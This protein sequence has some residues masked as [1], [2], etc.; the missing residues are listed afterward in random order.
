MVDKRMIDSLLS[1]LLGLDPDEQYTELQV[2][3]D[4]PPAPEVFGHLFDAFVA[5]PPLQYCATVQ[6][7]FVH[8]TNDLSRLDQ[9][10]GAACNVTVSEEAREEILLKLCDLGLQ[11]RYR[12]Q[13]ASLLVDEMPAVRANGLSLLLGG[14]SLSSEECDQVVAR[15]QDRD[16]GV[17][18]EAARV[19]RGRCPLHG[20][21]TRLLLARLEDENKYVQILA[22]EALRGRPDLVLH[23]KELVRLAVDHPYYMIRAELAESLAELQ[24]SNTDVVPD[25]LRG[26]AG[27]DMLVASWFALILVRRGVEPSLAKP[28]LRSALERATLEPRDRLLKAL[29]ALEAGEY[30]EQRKAD[31]S[32]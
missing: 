18:M 26:L 29:H 2:V 32:A 22:A 9:L 21:L 14:E 11:G 17:R 19:L 3:R 12:G 15:L 28:L 8:A 31:E 27:E 23:E 4:W 24:S 1:K 6:A 13:A 30:A 16:A 10:F 25:L 5:L 20:S 7:L